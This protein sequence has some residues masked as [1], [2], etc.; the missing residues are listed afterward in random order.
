MLCLEGI[1]LI[2]CKAANDPSEPL[3]V[4]TNRCWH[5]RQ[6]VCITAN[7]CLSSANHLGLAATS[8]R[9][10]KGERAGKPSSRCAYRSHCR[11]LRSGQLHPHTQ[12]REGFFQG[13]PPRRRGGA[14]LSVCHSLVYIRPLQGC[15][16]KLLISPV[17]MP[18][19]SKPFSPWFPT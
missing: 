18:A 3:S 8:E 4:F 12:Q 5:Q 7:R 10:F 1:P 15:N 11:P 14:C 16:S 9:S 6:F 13:T 17:Q 19:H 2:R